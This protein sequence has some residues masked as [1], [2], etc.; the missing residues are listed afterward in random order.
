MLRKVNAIC[1]LVWWLLT[2]STA[3]TFAY[4]TTDAA[5]QLVEALAAI[6]TLVA[7]FALTSLIRAVTSKQSIGTTSPERYT[8]ESI[9]VASGLY[10]LPI[11]MNAI[12]L[13][14]IFALGPAYDGHIFEMKGST[15]FVLS[16]SL[17]GLSLSEL[18]SFQA[19]PTKH[20]NSLDNGR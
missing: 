18:V 16:A 11:F 20:E 10:Y 19:L 12:A 8:V 9:L 15:F 2:Y 7:V 17:A 6:F 5:F 1:T 14:Y 3:G 13:G 4:Q